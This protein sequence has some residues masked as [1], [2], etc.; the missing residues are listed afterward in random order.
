MFKKK[1]TAATH[2]MITM[3]SD[4][5]RSHKPYALPVQYIACR[6]LKDQFVRDLN[7]KVKTEMKS[8]D[9]AVAG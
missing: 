1:R 6:T 7:A 4:E 9:M 3:L 2:V 5:K 8:R